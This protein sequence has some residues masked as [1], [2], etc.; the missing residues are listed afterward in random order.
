MVLFIQCIL[1]TLYIRNICLF[2]SLKSNHVLCLVSLFTRNDKICGLMLH[3]GIVH[4]KTKCFF[5]FIEHKKSHLKWC[6]S[7][8]FP[9]YESEWWLQLIVLRVMTCTFFYSSHKAI[10][11]EDLLKY[12]EWFI[13]TTLMV[14]LWSFLEFGSPWS[15]FT[16]ILWKKSAWTFFGIVLYFKLKYI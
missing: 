7:C 6:P 14:C 4:Q 5:F 2:I 9:H 3:K 15:P 10:T 12:C 16:F 1:W 13:W 11:L 8:S